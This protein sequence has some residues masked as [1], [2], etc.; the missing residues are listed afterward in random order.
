MIEFTEQEQNI[1]TDIHK[2]NFENLTPDE[3]QLYA[4]WKT[5]IALRDTEFQ[6]K[7]DAMKNEMQAR[8]NLTAEIAETAKSNLAELKQAA[9]ARLE[10]IDNG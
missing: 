1:I 7:Q 10:M 6:S 9:L 5:A 2:R 8:I 4:R 3:V